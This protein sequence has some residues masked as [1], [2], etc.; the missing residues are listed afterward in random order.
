M[1]YD[2][3]VGDAGR[4]SDGGIFGNSTFGQALEDGD[5]NIPEGLPMPGSMQE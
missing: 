4:H 1:W 2:Y 5:L 3:C